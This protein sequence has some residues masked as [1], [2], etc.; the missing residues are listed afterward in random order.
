MIS[1]KAYVVILAAIAGERLF[2]LFLSQ[3]NAR[4]ALAR[5]AVEVKQRHY[6]LMVAF[7]SIFLVSCAVESLLWERNFSPVITWAALGFTIFGQVLR[8][9]PVW[10]LGD[11]ENTKILF[12]RVSSR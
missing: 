1:E 4:R 2:E 8:Y 5:G 7:H 11:R 12:S 6:V 10:S 3:R 9:A